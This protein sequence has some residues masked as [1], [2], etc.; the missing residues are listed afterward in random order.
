MAETWRLITDPAFDG[1]TNMAMDEALLQRVGS[2][3]SPPVLRLFR[4][5]PPC[6]SLGVGQPAADADLERLRVR[7]WGIVRRLT[8]GRAILHTDEITY[9]VTLPKTHPLVVGS[10]VESYRRLSTGLLRALE[11]I[12]MVAQADP[13][14]PE[15]KH[16]RGPVCFEVPSNYEIAVNGKKMLGS[17]Q[18]RKFDGVLQHGSLPLMGDL[19][20]ICEGL[21]FPDEMSRRVARQRVLDRAITLAEALGKS[22][23]WDEMAYAMIE[24]FAETFDVQFAPSTL[25]LDEHRLTDDL[26]QARYANDEWT[27]RLIKSP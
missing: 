21:I 1:A 17:A 13:Q 24:A 19:G 3:H 23:S 26:R 10:I 12:G 14:A 18:V 6:L 8:G 2:G 7:G 22:P 5:S 4:W 20:R 9:S 15:A 25:T 16:L 27:L 11:G